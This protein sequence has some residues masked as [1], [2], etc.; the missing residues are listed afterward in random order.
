MTKCNKRGEKQSRSNF[1]QMPLANYCIIASL[2]ST[3]KITHFI[4]L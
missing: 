2:S 1:A 4:C 3:L